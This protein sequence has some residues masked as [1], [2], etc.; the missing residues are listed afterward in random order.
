MFATG[1]VTNLAVG[2]L[3]FALG[4]ALGLA[5]VLAAHTRHWWWAAMTS[6]ATTLASPVAGF[7]LALAWLAALLAHRPNRSTFGPAAC[8]AVAIVPMAVSAF[9]FPEEG[10]FPF[11]WNGLVVV[12][13][14]CALVLLVVPGDRASGPGA[15]LLRIGALLYSVTA[16]GTFVVANPLGGNLERLGMYVAAPLLVAVGS[17]RR[18]L[19]WA[20]VPLLLCWQWAPAVD[21]IFRAGAD[22]ST[23]IAYYQPLLDFLRSQPEVVGRI[24]IPFTQRHYEAAY[25]APVVPLARGWERQLDEVDNSLFYEDGLD[26]DSYR[27]WLMNTGVQ[28]VA[29]SDAS[30]DPSALDEAAIVASGPPYLEPAWSGAHWRVWRVVG[31]PGVVSGADLVARDADDLVIDAR[32]PGSVLVRVRWMDFWSLSGPGCV[33]PAADG[34]TWVEVGAPGQFVL[35]PALV[36]A[37]Q[38]C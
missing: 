29:L 34:W 1:T 14:V 38:H 23:D 21:G 35:R 32:T 13:G 4:L 19:L 2:R 28:F 17:R 31:S 5:A 10:A 20:A 11:R 12:L 22:P 27:D 18:V 37:K 24:E 9:L 6:V 26:A 16:V 25:V 3:A 33:A 36:G 15:R 7:F 30:L 8:A